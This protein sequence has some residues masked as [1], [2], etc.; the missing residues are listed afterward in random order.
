MSNTQKETT[1]KH[2][3]KN[4]GL[5]LNTHERAFIELRC[6]TNNASNAR[7]VHV[8]RKIFNALSTGERAAR[9]ERLRVK[10]NACGFRGRAAR[11]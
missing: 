4:F 9:A 10:L 7:L 5:K 8:R 11:K 6:C 1:I 3:E 2:L